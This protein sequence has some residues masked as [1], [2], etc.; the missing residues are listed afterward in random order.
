VLRF[1]TTIITDTPF[2]GHGD[3][4]GDLND[5]NHNAGPAGVFLFREHAGCAKEDQ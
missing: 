5:R 4:V 1:A 3:G 2:S